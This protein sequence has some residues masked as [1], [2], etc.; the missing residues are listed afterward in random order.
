MNTENK[1]PTIIR[2]N[3]SSYFTVPRATA[4]DRQLSFEARGV[5]M[6]LLSKPDDWQTRISDLQQG[7]GRDKI[8]RILAELEKARYLKHEHEHDKQG[9]F[10]Q[11][12]YRVYDVPQPEN[13]STENPLSKSYI[14]EEEHKREDRIKN[15]PLPIRESHCSHLPGK[16]PGADLQPAAP[17]SPDEPPE[18]QIIVSIIDAWLDAQGSVKLKKYYASKYTR[19]MALAVHK[20]GYTVAEVSGYVKWRKQDEFWRDKF[21][22]LEKV[23]E[24][25]GAY[26]AA[27]RRIANDPSRRRVSVDPPP[28][29]QITEEQRQNVFRIRDEL[30]AKMQPLKAELEALDRRE[31]RR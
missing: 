20:S 16:S 31:G 23:A 14:I 6:Y 30:A 8:R 17:P 28:E 1:Q 4:Q 26:R 12:I 9:R 21:V 27:Q 11:T 15:S 29:E 7:C 5:L 19:E 25:I 13:P 24:E 22:S 18:H 3:S 2:T 10:K